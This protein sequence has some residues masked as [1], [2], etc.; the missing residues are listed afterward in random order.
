MA[1]ADD[2]VVAGTSD[3]RGRSLPEVGRA[4]ADSVMVAGELPM[5]KLVRGA[6]FVDWG[7]PW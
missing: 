6:M 4:A 7:K 3:R 1:R 5:L 2:A